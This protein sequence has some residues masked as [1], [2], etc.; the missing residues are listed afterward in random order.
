MGDEKVMKSINISD[1]HTLDTAKDA[2]EHMQDPDRT[3]LEWILDLCV[4]ICANVKVNKM[5]PG[6]LGVVFGPN[7]MLKGNDPMADPMAEL[8]K[9]KIVESFL[10]QA[11]KYRKAQQ[12][13]V[14]KDPSQD[15]L[16]EQSFSKTTTTTTTTKIELSGS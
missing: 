3:V 16:N 10:V 15:S 1:K 14:G 13:S 12:N 4:K 5:S 11:I 7:F 8:Q 6:N 2:I 9:C